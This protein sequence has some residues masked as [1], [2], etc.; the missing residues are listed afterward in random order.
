MPQP[1][2]AEPLNV[3]QPD[4]SLLILE[5]IDAGQPAF[6]FRLT[7]QDPAL[8]LNLKL[9]GP[10][11]LKVDALQYFQ[12]FFHEIETLPLNSSREKIIAEHRLAAKGA[13]LFTSLLPTDLQLLLWSLRSSIR[14]VQVQSVEPWIPMGTLQTL[15]AGEWKSGRGPVPV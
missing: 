9:F 11:R 13:S 10:I 5:H 14:S 8:E 3:H 7:A 6:T 2:S 4:L 12:D 15:W 1:A